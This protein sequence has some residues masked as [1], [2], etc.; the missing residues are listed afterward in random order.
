MY[1]PIFEVFNSQSWLAANTT[2]TMSTFLSMVKN[3]SSNVAN[4]YLSQ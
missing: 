4:S 2:S 1:K 3:L